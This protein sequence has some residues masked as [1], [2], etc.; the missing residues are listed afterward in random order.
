MVELDKPPR[1][2]TLSRG[3]AQPDAPGRPSQR[4]SLLL[5]AVL[6]LIA[7]G[8]VLVLLCIW[9]VFSGLSPYFLSTS[10]ITNILVQSSSVAL[11]ALGALVVVMVGSLDLSL[12]STV[13][14][15]TIVGAVLYRDFPSLGWVVIPVLLVVGLAIGVLNAL[16]I[17]T[18]RIGNAFIVTL[19][20]LY[21]I[22]SLSYVV[23]EG[24]QVPG[25]PDHVIA[26][27][28]ESVV[29]IPGPVLLVVGVAALL[30]FLLNRVVWGRWI[31]AIGGNRDAAGKVGVPVRKV[32][33]SV[34]IIASVFAAI[35]GV[36]VAGLNNSGTVD[37][38]TSILQAIAAVVIGGASLTGGRGSVWATVVGAVI[39]GSITNG[40]TLLSVSTTWTPFAIGAVLVAAVGLD[41]LRN[42][43]EGR[44]RVRQAQLQTGGL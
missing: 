28:N 20:M 6:R 7:A 10:N 8:P 5:G 43:V 41:T 35:T 29:G 3:S 37:N 23:S 38:G 22:Q 40:L 11:L 34:Y 30:W 1:R 16:C 39:L 4:R 21:V 12:G 25:V 2:R 15:C 44:L 32:L 19:G 31:V 33:F 24:T 13:G 18:F 27:A 17:V 9:L 26:L 36:L 42:T 14:L